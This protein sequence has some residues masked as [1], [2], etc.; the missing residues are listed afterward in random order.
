MAFALIVFLLADKAAR[1]FSLCVPSCC[2]AR[3]ILAAVG[4]E[5]GR[6]E[7]AIEIKYQA[8]YFLTKLSPPTLPAIVGATSWR[9]AV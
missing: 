3:S 1:S 6:T 7:G 9:C 8:V 5:L 2:G 4:T